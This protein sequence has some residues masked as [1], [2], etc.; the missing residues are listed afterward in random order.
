MLIENSKDP[1]KFKKKKL[2]PRTDG[3]LCLNN[4]SWLPCY[5]DLRALIMHESYKSKYY[6]HPGSD[7]MY[8]DLKQLYWWPN[9]KADIA[10]YVSKCLTCLR[11]K[12][13]H[14]KP[15]GLLVQPEIPQWKWDNITMDFVTKLP[16]TSSGYDTI[17]VIVDHLTKSVQFLPM[18]EDDSMDKLT[19][20]YLKEVVTRHGIPILIIFD[21][22][23]RFT[24]N[25]WRAFQKVFGTR[26]DMSTA[27]HPKTDGHSERTIQT[28]E[29]M[30]RAYATPFEALYGRK[31]RSPVCWVEVGDAQ[32][33]GPEIIQETTEK[34]IQIKQRLQAAR[35]HQKS[36]ANVRHS[37]P[38]QLSRVHSTFH[39][40]NLK[41]CLSDEQ[42]AIPLD[43]LHIDDKLRFVEEPVEIMDQEIKRLRKFRGYKLA[44]EEEVKENE[45]LEEIVTQVTANVNNANGGGENGE[46]NGCSYKTFTACNPKEFHG[47]GGAVALT[48]W[49]E[50]MESVFDN[51]GCTANQRVRGTSMGWNLK[52]VVWF[53]RPSQQSAILT[54]GIL[55]DEAVRCGTLTNGND[56]RKEREESSKQGSTWKDNKK[57]KTG[58]G[59]V[60]TDP[61]RIDNVSTYP[62]YAKC[63]TFHPE[64][65]PCKLCYN[66]QKP[67]HYTRQCWSPISYDCPK[68]KQATGQTRNPLA[69]EGNRNT[70]NNRNQARGGAFNRNAV[71]ALQD[72]KVMTGTFSLNNQFATVLFDSK[73]DFSFISTKF[74]PLI[75]V[76]P[77]IVNPGY[78]IEIADGKS[79]EFDR[80]I[81]DYKMELGNSLFTI[82]LILLGHRSFDTKEEHEVYLMLVL[83]LL[84]KEKLYVK[85]YKC[86]FWLQE[87]HFLGHVVNQ[88]GIHADPSKIE[89]VKNWKAP[90]MPSEIRLFLGL[91]GYYRRFITNF[92]NIAKPLTLLTQKNQKYEWGKKEEEAFQTLKNNMCDASILSL[93]DG[94][95]DFIVYCDASNQGL[96]CVLMQRGKVIAYASRQLKIHEK[97]YT[98]HDL[99][100]RAVVFALKI[101]RYYFYGTKSVI[102]TD[103]KS[104]QHTFDQKELNMSQ[105]RKERVKPRR[106]RAMAMTIQSGVKEMILTAQRDARMVIMDEAHKSR[107]FVHPRADKMYHDLR[108]MHDAIWVIV[109]RLTKSAHFLVIHEDFSTEK[110]ARLYIDVIVAQHGVPVSIILD[111]DR[112]FT[113][114]FW[115][116]VQ[117]ALGTRLDLNFGGSWDVHI[118]LAEFSYNNIYHSSIRCAPFEALYDRKCRSYVLWAEIGEGSLIRPELVLETKNKVVLIKQKLKAARDHQKSYEDKRRKPL[119][120]DMGDRVLLKVLPWKGVVHLERRL[121]LPEELSSVHDTFHVSNL[122]KCLADANLHVPLDEIKVDKTLCFVEEPVE[123]MDR[124]IKKLKRKK[125]ALVKVR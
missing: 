56:K 5:G 87:V 6:V 111:R 24:S 11:V 65:A 86:E 16:R 71:D 103:H 59:F 44:T 53:G 116:M 41:K 92:S 36:Y 100:L 105:R 109:G 66:C 18:R 60:A 104:L 4:R 114:H 51:S 83:E 85:V 63:Y 77:C 10:T 21:R 37:L 50:T 3:I 67:C 119:E 89:A 115:Q 72:P 96:G 80:V 22:D 54:A 31:C 99:L 27:Y 121:R 69:L 39:V 32:L 76:E 98:T 15:S 9:M 35:D 62:K 88:S 110:L 94:I 97:N 48:R 117:K 113:L 61:L 19:K 34:I 112:R 58:Q 125:I 57:P 55:T 14:Q 124:E 42:L 43:E 2:E 49:I 118:P 120:F 1:E 90:T 17:W 23:P 79:V 74:A 8:Q 122:N 78:V 107:Y 33:T 25:F 20:L 81:C 7:K 47:K 75:N 123:I 38:Q 82:D 68:W 84:R 73:A 106:V 46:N 29:D 64:K 95:E 102:Y 93:P 28:L 40:S 30:L 52:C 91:A 12:S 101:Y 45:G 70:R 13:E 26:M 108:D